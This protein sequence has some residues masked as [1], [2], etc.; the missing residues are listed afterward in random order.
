[1][2]E[3]RDVA[4]R[5]ASV[6]QLLRS[7]CEGGACAGFER[8]R[9]VAPTFRT[10]EVVRDRVTGSEVTVVYTAFHQAVFPSP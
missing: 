10:G 2:A 4:A 7:G 9:L 8:E 1:M 3:P 6:R 5:L